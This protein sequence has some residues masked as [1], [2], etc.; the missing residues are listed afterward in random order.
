MPELQ[1]QSRTGV[2]PN[3]AERLKAAIVPFLPGMEIAACAVLA[4]LLVWKGILPGWRFLNT[5][6]P[7]YYL[8]AR[9]L[10]EGYSLDRVYDWIW[11]QRIK[12]HWGISQQLVGFAGLTPFSALPVLPLSFFS[13]LI[14]KRLWILAN[15]FW[16]VSTAELLNKVTFLGRRRIWLLCR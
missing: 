6:F 11:L 1:G 7:N 16:L 9:L 13:I 12:D 8:V 2:L 15:L 3:P 4:A 5:D 10:R 14:A